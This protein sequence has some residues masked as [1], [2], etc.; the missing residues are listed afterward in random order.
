M[1]GRLHPFRFDLLSSVKIRDWRPTVFKYR[2]AQLSASLSLLG[3]FVVFYAFQATSTGFLVYT[4]G[5]RGE[6]ALCVG[7]PRRS[8]LALGPDGEFIMG[9]RE[10]DRSCSQ[11]KNLSIVSTDSPHLIRFGWILVILGFISQMVAIERPIFSEA[12]TR[13]LKKLRKL[14]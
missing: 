13:R 7:D 11:G 8:M 12:E 3:S 14:L 10:F 5:P 6:S 1:L 4:H 2:L 9:M